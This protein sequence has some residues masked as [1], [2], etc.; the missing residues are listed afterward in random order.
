MPTEDGLKAGLGEGDHFVR[1]DNIAGGAVAE[2]FDEE[3]RKILR[4]IGDVN[5]EAEAVREINIKIK[6]KPDE[7]RRLGA[8]A[9]SV[10]SKVAPVKRVTTAFYLG[11]HKNEF[12]A[13]ESNPQQRGLFENK[14]DIQPLAAPAEKGA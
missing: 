3:L 12:V 11:R 5:T 13:V 4:N 6:I 1:L 7:G 14:P 9:A 10:T 2:L 8:V